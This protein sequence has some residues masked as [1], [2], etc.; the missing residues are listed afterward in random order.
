MS[1]RSPQHTELGTPNGWFAVAWSKDLAPGDVKRIHYFD[2][3]LVLFR[4]RSGAP[5]VL[6]AYCAH[7]GAHLAE[8]GRVIGETIR[9][10]F[11]G[12]QYDGHGQCTHIPYCDQIPAKARVRAWDVVERDH[13]IF[14]WHHAEG[15]PPSWE[16]PLMAE[17]EDPEWT[18]PRTFEL[19]VA[20][21]MQEMAENNCD[22][23]HFQYV[24]GMLEV[25][26]SEISYSEDGRFMRMVSSG[27]QETSLGTFETTLERDTWGLGLSSV[28]I[29][30][31]PGA[32]LLMFSST[33]P[34]DSGHAHSRWLFT[35]TENLADVAGEEFISGM[36]QGVLQDVR[37]W[38]NKIHRAHPVLCKADQYLIEFRRWTKQFYSEQVRSKERA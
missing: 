1:S 12:W 33:S 3:E 8:G 7:L 18:E 16:V 28:R 37:I 19:E 15:K 32:G 31:I 2:E 13:M 25:P 29:K 38:K 26:P 27:K 22:P 6:D 17:F 10:P 11:H 24:H 30:G 35:V 14:V 4:T 21:H 20:V 36:S 9:C 23:V 34:V 5:Q